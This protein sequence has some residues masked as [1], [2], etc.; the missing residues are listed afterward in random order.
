MNGKI[1]G[2]RRKASKVAKPA[3]GMMA[4]SGA[5]TSVLDRLT[6][7]FDTRFARMQT[8]T[9]RSAMETAFHASPVELGK[10]ALRAAHLQL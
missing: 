2:R 8:R 10:A 1:Q 5:A 7:E 6:A 9:V 4:L 3:H